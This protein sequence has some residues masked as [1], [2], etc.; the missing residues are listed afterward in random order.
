MWF[1]FWKVIDVMHALCHWL[2]RSTALALYIALSACGKP[3]VA[4]EVLQ[5]VLTQVVALTADDE[6]TIYSG[7]VRSRYEIPLSF[8]IPGKIIARPVDNGRLVKPGEELARLDPGDSSLALRA[9]EATLAQARAEML[10]YRQ[11]RQKNFISASALEARETAFKTAQAQTDLARNQSAYTVLS[12]EQSGVIGAIA[13]EVGQV[14]SAG[15]I[16][17]RLA[18][19]ETLEVVI[20]IPESR[21]PALR[22][23]QPA[24]VTLWADTQARYAAVLRELSPVADPVTRTYAAR[25]AIRQADQRLRLGMTASVRFRQAGEDSRLSVPLSAIFQQDGQPAVWVVGADK[26]VALR[27]VRVAA[28]RETNALLDSGLQR[29]ERIVVAGVH[30][31]TSGE[32]IRAVEAA[33]APLP[34]TAAS[35]AGPTR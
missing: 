21:V 18:R 10:R 19:P 7:E 32:T 16:V 34:A 1:F 12:A 13:A 23:Q 14:V 5:P 8:R 15:Q 27:P 33:A 2:V 6:A 24:E 29:G 20:A 9:A 22:L 35:V 28:Y 17:M 11:L 31:L 26:R 4:G 30:K 3:E 25:V